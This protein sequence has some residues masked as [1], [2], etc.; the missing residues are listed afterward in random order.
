M[1]AGMARR[2]RVESPDAVESRGIAANR[3]FGEER[4][5][6]IVPGNPGLRLDRL[7]GGS[8]MR[9]LRCRS[10]AGTGKECWREDAGRRIVWSDLRGRCSLVVL[11]LL[12][13]GERPES[14]VGRYPSAT[15]SARP[16]GFEYPASRICLYDFSFCATKSWKECAG[17]CLMAQNL[18]SGF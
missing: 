3:S 12:R 14:G 8:R 15:R 13:V 1:L 16:K 5:P 4:G 7:P 6:E 11:L 10:P 18:E 9:Q 2:L 17:V